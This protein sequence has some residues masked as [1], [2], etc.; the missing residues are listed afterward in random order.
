MPEETRQLTSRREEEEGWRRAKHREKA[1]KQSPSGASTLDKSFLLGLVEGNSSSRDF[2]PTATVE[3]GGWKCEDEQN[4][5]LP[6]ELGK[7]ESGPAGL[8]RRSE[9]PAGS[10]KPRMAVKDEMPKMRWK[11]TIQDRPT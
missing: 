2:Q 1:A 3:Q 8:Q 11:P 9:G 4:L 5:L 10:W 6:A 7:G